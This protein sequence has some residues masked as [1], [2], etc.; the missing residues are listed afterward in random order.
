LPFLGAIPLDPAIAK[1]SDEGRIEEYS[2]SIIT[3]IV[4][5]LRARAAKQVEQLTQALPIAWS[6]EHGR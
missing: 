2:N 5:E 4:D 3:G 6:I 1:L